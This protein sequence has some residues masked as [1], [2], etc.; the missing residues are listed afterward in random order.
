MAQTSKLSGAKSR[1]SGNT[2]FMGGLV[3]VGLSVIGGYVMLMASA[4]ELKKQNADLQKALS[5]EQTARKQAEEAKKQA[6]DNLSLA[7]AALK[8]NLAKNDMTV[9]TTP[10]GRGWIFVCK[11]ANGKWTQ[12]VLDQG[13]VKSPEEFSRQ[14][15]TVTDSVYIRNTPP[16]SDRRYALGEIIGV[17]RRGQKVSIGRMQQARAGSWYGEVLEVTGEPIGDKSLGTGF[18]KTSAISGVRPDI[19]IDPSIKVQPKDPLVR[20]PSVR[21]PGATRLNPR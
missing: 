20:D 21:N 8:E 7:Q 19:T 1:K 16:V 5:G 6:E 11:V 17:A 2:L 14:N 4:A 12:S 9:E 10:R 3:L 18:F 15:A 13:N